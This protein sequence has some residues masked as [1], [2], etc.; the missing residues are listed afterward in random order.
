MTNTNNSPGE[1]PFGKPFVKCDKIY[2]G[3]VKM[4]LAITILCVGNR[5][6]FVVKVSL[7]VSVVF[8]KSIT[9]PIIV[10]SLSGL[11]NLCHHVG[12]RCKIH[13]EK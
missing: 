2:S 11:R 7:K 13:S 9:N 8:N 12:C 3:S 10:L 6:S 1:V 5:I 4:G